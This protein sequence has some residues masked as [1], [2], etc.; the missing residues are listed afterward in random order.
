MSD[1]IDTMLAEV[2]RL[3]REATS[4][5][6]VDGL[7]WLLRYG[8]KEDGP[9]N[10]YEEEHADDAALIAYYRTAVPL[11][12]AEVERLRAEREEILMSRRAALDEIERLRAESEHYRV[13]L[14]VIRLGNH[15]DPAAFACQV[16]MSEP[17]PLGEKGAER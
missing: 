14:K 16:L 3:A 1:S 7:R 9:R 6:N 10:D 13:A 5:W 12:A 11:L 4:S 8:S 15:P 17:A 2:K